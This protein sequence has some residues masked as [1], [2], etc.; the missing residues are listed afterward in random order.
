MTTQRLF[1]SLH[2]SWWSSARIAAPLTKTQAAICSGTGA[3]SAASEH[4]YESPTVKRPQAKR[5]VRQGERPSVRCSAL[6]WLQ[7][8][9]G[10]SAPQSAA[11]SEQARLAGNRSAVVGGIRCDAD[12]RIPRHDGPVGDRGWSH[13]R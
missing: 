4:S 9:V 6:S 7:G 8:S 10:F 1:G 12:A 3:A 13:G 2:G 11:S 5:P